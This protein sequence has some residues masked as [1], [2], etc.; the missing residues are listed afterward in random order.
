MTLQQL[1]LDLEFFMC[2]VIITVVTDGR[3]G[4]WVRRHPISVP[5]S[6]SLELHDSLL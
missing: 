1:P 5:G 6:S 4:G 2:N 3:E